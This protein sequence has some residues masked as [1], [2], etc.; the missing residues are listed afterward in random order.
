MGSK[1]KGRWGGGGGERKGRWG[2]RRKEDGEEGGSGKEDD[3]GLGLG[4]TKDER[5]TKGVGGGGKDDREEGRRG[6]TCACVC[7]RVSH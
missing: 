3:E 5:N 2:V 1:K 6:C 7:R 4:R